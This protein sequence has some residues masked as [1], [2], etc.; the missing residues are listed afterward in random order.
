MSVPPFEERGT[1]VRACWHPHPRMQKFVTRLAVEMHNNFERED[2]IHR[3]AIY[4]KLSSDTYR[5]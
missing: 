2:V 5:V 3:D 1:S 4:S